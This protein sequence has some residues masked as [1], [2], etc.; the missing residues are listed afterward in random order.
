MG[1]IIGRSAGLDDLYGCLGA[2]EYIVNI[3]IAINSE[4]EINTC[5]SLEVLVL[6]SSLFSFCRSLYSSA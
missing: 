4:S 6:P 2:V 3:G 5:H 1:K